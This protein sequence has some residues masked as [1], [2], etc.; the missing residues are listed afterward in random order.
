[1]FAGSKNGVAPGK[2]AAACS[3]AKAAELHLARC[4]AEEL[5]SKRVRFNTVNPDAVLDGSP[6]RDSS[7]QQERARA[8]GIAPEELEAFYRARP[9]LIVNVVP[10]DVAE[11]IVFFA[12]PGR[13]GN[14]TGNI[15]DVDG[16]VSAAFRR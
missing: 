7:W 12:S 3:P 10:D 11:A 4:L 14:H 6:I 9:A 5:G 13:S 16:G 15:L 2:G 1:M 8:H